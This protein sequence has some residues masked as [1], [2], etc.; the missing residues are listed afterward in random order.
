MLKL[1]AIQMLSRL[2][3]RMNVSPLALIVSIHAK[4]GAENA[5]M[6]QIQ[7]HKLL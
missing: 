3:A 1:S 7:N 4:E 6:V 2:Y 5:G